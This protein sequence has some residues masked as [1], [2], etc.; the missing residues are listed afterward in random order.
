VFLSSFFPFSPLF[1]SLLSLFLR[2]RGGG[3][4]E[5]GWKE[6]EEREHKLNPQAAV[7]ESAP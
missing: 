1:D 2:G 4:G 3:E 5:E 7:S 6:G